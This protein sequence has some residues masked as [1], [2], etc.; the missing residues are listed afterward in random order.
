VQYINDSIEQSVSE[1]ECGAISMA[2]ILTYDKYGSIA[3]EV[4]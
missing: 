1:E 3:L 2:V 4:I